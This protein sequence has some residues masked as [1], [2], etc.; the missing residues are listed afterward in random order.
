MV[1]ALQTYDFRYL[2]TIVQACPLWKFCVSWRKCMR[3]VLNL[4]QLTHSKYLPII[5]DKMDIKTQLLCRFTKFWY[6]CKNSSNNI[7]KLCSNLCLYSGSIVAGNLRE[8]M[9]RVS[10]GWN[11]MLNS[12]YNAGV[13]TKLLCN[14][15]LSARVDV[16]I[17]VSTAIKDLCMSRDHL[18][19]CGLSTTEV[20]DFLYHLSV[21]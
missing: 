15:D 13:I 8:V 17:A 16:D 5:I 3:R 12:A 11:D 4:N 14:K 20:E 21:T 2:I 6:N 10:A 7:V 18:F 9:S 1:I 19:S